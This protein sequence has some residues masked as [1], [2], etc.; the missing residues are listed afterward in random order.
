MS[1]N[2]E[3]YYSCWRCQKCIQGPSIQSNVTHVEGVKNGVCSCIQINFTHVGIVKS[4][5]FHIPC[6]ALYEQKIKGY[7]KGVKRDSK[8]T[9]RAV[10]LCMLRV[11]KEVQNA[12]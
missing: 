2:T 8:Y 1:L 12:L 3:Q 11:L 10:I 9:I 5:L 6:T 7:V 4:E